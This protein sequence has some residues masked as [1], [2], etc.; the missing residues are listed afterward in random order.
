MN[1][2]LYDKSLKIENS[3]IDNL[4]VT[5]EQFSDLTLL[6]RVIL[7][8]LNAENLDNKIDR[9][10]KLAYKIFSKDNEIGKVEFNHLIKHKRTIKKYMEYQSYINQAY[11]IVR[12][13]NIVNYH[14]YIDMIEDTYW[15]IVASLCQENNID[16]NIDKAR[17]D[18]VQKNSD[19]IFDSIF[20][21]L[22]SYVKKDINIQNTYK[23]NKE[24]AITIILV[25]AFIDCNILENPNGGNI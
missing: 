23:E 14:R 1:D 5:L 22:L 10:T 16:P 15:D 12:L 17:I 11:E 7:S 2:T 21:K 3:K 6:G 19:E 18:F 8:F 13:D 25:K 9:K 4:E 20:Q 24:R